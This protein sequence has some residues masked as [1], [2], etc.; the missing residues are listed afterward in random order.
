MVPVTPTAD[1][2][3]GLAECRMKKPQLYRLLAANLAQP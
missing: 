1:N 3:T 2:A